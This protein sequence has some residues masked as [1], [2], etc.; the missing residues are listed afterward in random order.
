M[1]ASFDSGLKEKGSWDEV[2]VASLWL[3]DTSPVVLQTGVRQEA[4]LF[5]H[6]YGQNY[7][8]LQF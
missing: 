2:R 7:T 8:V 6:E 1:S 5:L 3:S 4:E